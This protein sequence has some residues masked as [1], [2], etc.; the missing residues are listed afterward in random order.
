MGD[1]LLEACKNMGMFWLCRR[2]YSKS[3]RIEY[4]Y[5]PLPKKNGALNMHDIHAAEQ[6]E[7]IRLISI[8]N[9]K[10]RGAA[11]GVF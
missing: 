9:D 3:R 7:K 2:R 1:I 10:W 4:V 11:H 5:D 6:S 8:H